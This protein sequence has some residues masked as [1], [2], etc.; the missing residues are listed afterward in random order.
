MS[1]SA[2]WR[3]GASWVASIREKDIQGRADF[4]ADKLTALSL[5]AV[6]DV[7]PP[8]HADIRGWP[9]EKEARRTRAREL[10]RDLGNPPAAH[11][12]KP[13]GVA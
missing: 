2:V 5:E 10:A 12:A 1:E 11:I 9:V 3:F 7:P 8:R 6:P 13:L 4:I